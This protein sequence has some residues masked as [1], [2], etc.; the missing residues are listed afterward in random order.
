M[1]G[2]SIDFDPLKFRVMNHFCHYKQ[3]QDPLVKLETIASINLISK[4]LD[5]LLNHFCTLSS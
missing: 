4:D 2:G 5:G 1:L 3:L